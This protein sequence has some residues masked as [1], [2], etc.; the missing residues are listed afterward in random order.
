MTLE[1]I[2][3]IT[4]NGERL[5]LLKKYIEEQLEIRRLAEECFSRQDESTNLSDEA[6]L[7]DEAGGMMSRFGKPVE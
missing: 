5:A 7:R 6:S 2:N 1:E 4:D 3:E